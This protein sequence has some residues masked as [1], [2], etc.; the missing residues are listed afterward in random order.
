MQTVHKTPADF[1]LIRILRDIN[2]GT[3]LSPDFPH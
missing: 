1:S 2:H 3:D